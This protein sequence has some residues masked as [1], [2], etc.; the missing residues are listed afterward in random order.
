VLVIGAG[1]GRADGIVRGTEP[2]ELE[3]RLRPYLGAQFPAFELGRIAVG[4]DREVLFL[5]AQPPRDGQ[6]ISPCHKSFQGGNRQDNLED[7]A[8]YVRGIVKTCGSACH[9][10]C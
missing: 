4:S 6:A 1:K 2:H 5:I 8:I 3:D 7:S 10:T 9:A